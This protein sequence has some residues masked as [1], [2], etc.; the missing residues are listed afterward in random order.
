MS[1]ASGDRHLTVLFVDDK[2]KNFLIKRRLE[3]AFEKLGCTVALSYEKDPDA[4][5]ALLSAVPRR[6]DVLIADLLFRAV[7]DTGDSEIEEPRG[8]VLIR[9]VRAAHPATVIIAVTTQLTMLHPDLVQRAEEAGADRVLLRG[10][11]MSETRYGG[12]DQLAREIFTFAVGHGLIDA[13]P[14]LDPT[15]D[16]GVE[17]VIEDVG[18]ARLRLLLSELS[19]VPGVEPQSVSLK[20]VAPGASGASVLRAEAT[21]P[22]GSPRT[23]LVKLGRDPDALAREVVNSRSIQG[24][25]AHNLVVRYLDRGVVTRSGWSA[26]A[27][28]FGHDAVTLR[29][30]LSDPASAP[31]VPSLFGRLFLNRGLANG[32]RALAG[33]ASAEPPMSKLTLPPFRRMQARAAVEGLARLLDHPQGVRIAD[34]AAMLK[35]IREY[36]RDGRID[37]VPTS[38]TPQSGLVMVNAHGD[39]HGGNVLVY[40]D[41]SPHPLI[42]DLAS[43]EPHHW[44]YDLARLVADI[45]LRALDSPAE[46]YFWR[47]FDE[48]RR[49]ARSAGNLDADIVDEPT[50]AAAVA[51]LNWIGQHREVL[52]AG[53]RTSERWWEWHVALAE[54]LLRGTYQ[55]HLP[56]PKRLLGLVAAYD[57]LVVARPRIPARNGW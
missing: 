13:G 18:K 39:L 25:Y 19:P 8:V 51:A 55:P 35:V 56:A 14:V 32:Y 52:L 10:N 4:A 6:F 26:I 33:P 23:L 42:I 30:W 43:Y 37:G 15:D 45:V 9:E 2:E 20:Y 48:W 12:T 36:S 49:I 38:D 29:R 5:Y 31:R 16:P 11:L 34:G 44:A 17:T 54:Q 24:L 3:S 53:L 46:L 22:D 50:N 1:I 28:E 27:T 40:D 47:R 21:M 57:Q 41:E 7:G